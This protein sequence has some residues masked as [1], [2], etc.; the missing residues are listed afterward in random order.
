MRIFV[1]RSSVELF[2][3]GGRVAMTNLVFPTNPY[4]QLRFFSDG[5]AKVEKAVAYTLNVS[6][7]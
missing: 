2:V 4:S 5:E 6:S 7:K 3:D 1:D